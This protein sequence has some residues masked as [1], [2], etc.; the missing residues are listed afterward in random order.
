MAQKATY[1]R[2]A[3]RF[4]SSTAFLARASS[5]RRRASRAAATAAASSGLIELGG[6][7]PAIVYHDLAG[8]LMMPLALAAF[9]RMRMMRIGVSASPPRPTV[10]TAPK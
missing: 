8:W 5:A 6:G 1:P 2:S 4:A 10:N 9:W 3:S 7:F